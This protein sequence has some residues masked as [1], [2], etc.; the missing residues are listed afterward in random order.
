MHRLKAVLRQMGA[1]DSHQFEEWNGEQEPVEFL[2]ASQCKLLL[3]YRFEGHEAFQLTGED[4]KDA[5]EYCGFLFVSY[6]A[7][8]WWFEI[9]EML[10]KL[11]LSALLIFVFDPNVRVAV[12]FLISFF[13]LVVVLWTRPFVSSSLDVLMAV[14]LVSQTLTFSCMSPFYFVFE[15][16]A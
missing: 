4:E 2:K 13:S 3:K 16:S 15:A 1:F 11:A 6:Q 5:I 9:F 12:G 10:R 7:R 14:A 8:Y